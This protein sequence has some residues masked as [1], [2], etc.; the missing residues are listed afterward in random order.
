MEL[1]W[2][3][4][5]SCTT[6]C[7]ILV[8]IIHFYLIIQLPCYM[9]LLGVLH[10]HLLLHWEWLVPNETTNANISWAP[11][12]IDYCYY[13]DW[14]LVSYELHHPKRGWLVS[15]EHLFPMRMLVA[16]M[17]SI[18]CHL[19]PPTS[20]LCPTNYDLQPMTYY[21]RPTTYETYDLRVQP[22]TY[23]LW[24]MTYDLWPMTYDLG[25]RT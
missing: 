22:M 12:A 20:H 2:S 17:K 19:L 7:C 14:E 5:V 9:L 6:Y 25:P 16:P 18:I 11:L 15:D 24:S 1:L 10:V 23:D 21:I 8:L 13:W 3:V 4:L